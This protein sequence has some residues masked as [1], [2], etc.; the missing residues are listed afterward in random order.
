MGEF[1]KYSDSLKGGPFR[2]ERGADVDVG[3]TRST[4]LWPAHLTYRQPGDRGGMDH[5]LVNRC[6]KET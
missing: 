4:G 3:A 2:L 1:A 6:T 5:L